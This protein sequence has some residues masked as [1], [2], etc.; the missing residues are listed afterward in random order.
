MRDTEA[1]LTEPEL[2]D[3]LFLTGIA[4]EISDQFVRFVGWVHVPELGGETAERRIRIR[5]VLTN[6]QTRNLI[7]VLRKGMAR[8]GH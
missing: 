5:Y 1:P 8:G 6:A 4:A 7:A 2:V 3:C